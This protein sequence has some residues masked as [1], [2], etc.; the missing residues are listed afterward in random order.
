MHW[1]PR[2]VGGCP[3]GVCAPG[4]ARPLG[5]VGGASL[6]TQL[7]SWASSASSGQAWSP[8]PFYASSLP[9]LSLIPS[10]ILP[11]NRAKRTFLRSP[12]ISMLPRGQSL[13]SPDLTLS[14]FQGLV[15]PPPAATPFLS[16]QIL[17]SCFSSHPPALPLSLLSWSLIS[18]GQPPPHTSSLSLFKGPFSW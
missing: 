6:V 2:F 16:S 1:G 11:E 5:R 14:A 9:L 3:T 8:A 13:V 7:A 18:S 17:L 10:S 15:P 4:P 12:V